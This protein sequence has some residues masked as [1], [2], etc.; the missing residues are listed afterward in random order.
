MVFVRKVVRKSKKRCSYSLN[1]PKEVIE[2][3]D[4]IGAT[5]KLTIKKDRLIITKITDESDDTPKK[6]TTSKPEDENQYGSSDGLI[7]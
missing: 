5:I 1:F 2:R 4:L 3:L 7:I 6:I